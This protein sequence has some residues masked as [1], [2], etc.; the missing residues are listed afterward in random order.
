MYRF[1]YAPTL[2]RLPF[3]TPTI[4]IK[5]V[6]PDCVFHE[7]RLLSL[8]AHAKESVLTSRGLPSSKDVGVSRNVPRS[9]TMGLG[10]TDMS[11]FRLAMLLAFFMAF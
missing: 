2:D 10:M 1:P 3:T 11:K 7:P 8:S 5:A 6:F 4:E 9:S